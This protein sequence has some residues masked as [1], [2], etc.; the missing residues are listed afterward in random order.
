MGAAIFH[1]RFCLGDIMAEI[2]TI[3]TLYN[4]YRFRSRLEARW[5]V[6]F[7]EA[8]IP[9][10]Y[11]KDGFVV[12]GKPYL[13]DFFL[14][15]FNC[16]VEIKPDFMDDKRLEQVGKLMESFSLNKPILL[17]I[18]EPIYSQMIMFDNGKSYPC[19]FVEG[20][21]WYFNGYENYF[22]YTKHF[23]SIL[24]QTNKYVD[25]TASC[26]DGIYNYSKEVGVHSN[27]YEFRYDFSQEKLKARQSRFE[28][29]EE[30]NK[31]RGKN[32]GK[33]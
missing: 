16:Y 8:G 12:D 1:G 19:K 6:F 15:W 3:E 24:C 21:V 18:G 10:E 25:F 7:D 11:E 23:V 31:K 22:G 26:T 17:C 14:P 33:I 28:H 29:G 32:N 4:G 5:A 9:Y 20:C 2:K 30:P 27:N 13:P